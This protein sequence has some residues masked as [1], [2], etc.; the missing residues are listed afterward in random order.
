M[1]GAGPHRQGFGT[2]EQVVGTIE[3]VMMVGADPHRQGFG[4]VEQVMVGADPQTR[5]WDGWAGG[6]D[7]WAGDD[8]GGWSSQTRIWD[9]WAGLPMKQSALACRL[10]AVEWDSWCRPC[11]SLDK[12]RLVMRMIYACWVDLIS[13]V[14]CAAHCEVTT[15]SWQM[16]DCYLTTSTAHVQCWVWCLW[17]WWHW[18]CF[19]CAFFGIVP[20]KLLP[21]HCC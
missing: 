1:V 12:W 5:I 20:H 21:K 7:Y 16:F 15:C 14:K 19:S 6:W 17:F 10:V 13:A 9:S 11:C 18:Q 2:V 4:T 8:G 3:Q